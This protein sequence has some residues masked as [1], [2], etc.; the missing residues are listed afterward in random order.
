MK[1]SAMNPT[2][3]SFLASA[4][5]LGVASAAHSLFGLFV[6]PAS[7]ADPPAPA[8]APASGYP[9]ASATVSREFPS[10][11]PAV[12]R[13]VVGASH[14]KFDRVKELVTARPALAK[15]TWDWGFGDWESALGAASHVG[16]RDIAM[17][18]LEHGAAPTIFSAAMLGQLD[19]VRSFVEASP[20][21]Q[22]TLGPHGISLLRH[23]EAGGEEANGVLAYLEEL[24]DADPRPPTVELTPEDYERYIGTYAFGNAPGDFLAVTV[25][26]KGR[27]RIT[28]GDQPAR[29]LFGVGDHAFF[30]SGAQ[31]VRVRFDVSNGRAASLSVHDPDL[32]LTA[33]RV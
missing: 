14:T 17:L 9:P 11:D 12:V 8:E 18:L 13:E 15:A 30:P 10:Q 16:R 3:R 4:A 33:R 26:D 7:A 21:T 28:R 31:A 27:L 32:V 22:G 25:D 6:R 24:G 29:F 2:R 19:V 20:G 23:A 1:E 5:G